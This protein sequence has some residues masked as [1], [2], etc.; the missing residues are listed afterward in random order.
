MAGEVGGAD[1]R[2]CESGAAALACATLRSAA[3]GVLHPAGS[4]N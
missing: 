1:S 2:V 4:R 3:A